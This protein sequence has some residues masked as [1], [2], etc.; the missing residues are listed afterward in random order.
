VSIVVALTQHDCIVSR[1]S[2]NAEAVADDTD[3]EDDEEAASA[4]ASPRFCV[5]CKSLSAI[6]WSIEP[7]QPLVTLESVG[8][9]YILQVVLSL[10]K[11][12]TFRI[13]P[14]VLVVLT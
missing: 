6:S 12:H 4:L 9:I 7:S 10:L 8:L 2:A 11:P 14:G 3:D 5:L 13:L 1:C